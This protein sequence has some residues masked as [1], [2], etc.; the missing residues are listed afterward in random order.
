[1]SR[2][3]FFAPLQLQGWEPFAACIIPTGKIRLLPIAS[4]DGAGRKQ[5]MKAVDQNSLRGARILVA[6]DDAILALDV[7][8]ILRRA[9][10][11]VVGPAPTLKQTLFMISAFPVSAALLDVNLR[12]G[13]VFPA[14]RALEGLGAGIVF[15][16]G[17]AD[18]ESLRRTWPVAEVL[19]KPAPP[20]LLVSAMRQA[21]FPTF[22]KDLPDVSASLLSDLGARSGHR[23][24]I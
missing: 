8:Q 24:Q 22:A 23:E 19:T 14:A 1:M 18:V 12:D 21:C 4:C 6:E 20:K 11:E 2:V 9:G 13:E 10:A 7:A 16:T 15:Y 5:K 17:Y 3:C